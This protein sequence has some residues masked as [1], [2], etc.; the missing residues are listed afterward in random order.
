MPMPL[1]SVWPVSLSTFQVNVGSSLRNSVSVFSS[2][3]LS[4]KDKLEKTLT[5]LRKEDPTFTWKVDKETGQTLMSGMG[6][7][8]LEIKQHRMER[9]F[10]L[11][12]RVGK[13]RVSYRETLRR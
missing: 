6:M 8:H 4:D 12:I 9:D 2:L 5:L 7:L 1:I 3:S 11:K 13:P 10:H